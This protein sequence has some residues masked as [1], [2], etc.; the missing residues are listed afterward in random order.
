MDVSGSQS[1]SN[2]KN[3]LFLTPNNMCF[4]GVNS[5]QI[6]SWEGSGNQDVDLNHIKNIKFDSME[7]ARSFYLGYA[8]G[9]GVGIRATNLDHDHEGRVLRRKSVCDKQGSRR[10][11]Y[12]TNKNRKRKLRLQTR[13]NCKACFSIGLNSDTLKY[14]VKVIIDDHLH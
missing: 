8:G 13:Q 12:L 7:D 3:G 2:I 1:K 5:V 9:N 4:T 11:E 6:S 10:E 14:S